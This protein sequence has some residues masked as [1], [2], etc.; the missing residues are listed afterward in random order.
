MTCSSLSR[1][2]ISLT[3]RAT[4]LLLLAAAACAQTVRPVISELGNPGKGRVEYYNDSAYPL[5]VVVEAKSFSVSE[6]GEI[7]Y[8]P[9]DSRVKLKLSATSFRIPPQQSYF[10][11]YEASVPDAP[12]WFVLYAA[13]SGFPMR[14]KE[15]LGI[16]VEL[17][18]TVYLLPKKGAE[19]QDLRVS[20]AE[21]DEA[22]KK[23]V[24]TVENTGPNF[25]RVL[26]STLIG[27]KRQD[28]PGF[29]VFPHARRIVELKWEKDGEPRRIE[30]EFDKFKLD[31][32][33]TAS[34]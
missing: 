24:L 19:K 25:T 5:N 3:L 12:A 6:K 20:Q 31:A 18:H 21:F 34:P 11:F 16:K 17:P 2:I 29:P 30:L 33:V 32:P 9:L 26:S 10:L 27:D 13:F 14:T 23:L 1:K 7:S 22:T 28:G 4:L 8:S 15:G